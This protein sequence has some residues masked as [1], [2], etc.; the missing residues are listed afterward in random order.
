MTAHDAHRSSCSASPRGG[1]AWRGSRRRTRPP[2]SP[3]ARRA[4]CSKCTRIAW[5]WRGWNSTT[6]RRRGTCARWRGSS[7]AFAATLPSTRCRLGRSPGRAQ[8]PLRAHPSCPPRGGAGSRAAAPPRA[9]LLPSARRGGV[10]RSRPSSRI[11]PRGVPGPR[12]ASAPPRASLLG[13]SGLRDEG[14]GR[15]VVGGVSRHVRCFRGRINWE[16]CHVM[17]AV[18]ENVS[19]GR[20][21]VMCVVSENVSIGRCVTSCALFVITYQ[22]G[23]VSRPAD[24]IGGGRYLSY[25]AACG[26]HTACSNH[27]ACINHAACT[28]HAACITHAAC[29]NH[30]ARGNP[31][32]TQYRKPPPPR[33]LEDPSR[34]LARPPC[35]PCNCP[36]WAH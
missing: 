6:S 7:L 33:P 3:R 35:S 31:E 14:R 26:S 34:S 12:A 2:R 16:V 18:S 19:I 30:A 29:I 21:H 11:P 27:A 13:V 15:V 28:N 17:C 9:S 4:A 10:A 25:R 24:R 5:R 1:S 23:G 36:D 32:I 8:P 22:L 20:C